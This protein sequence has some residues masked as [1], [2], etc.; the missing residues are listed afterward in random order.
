MTDPAAPDAVDPAF[1]PLPLVRTAMILAAIGLLIVVVSLAT[2]IA[3][4]RTEGRLSQDL[5]SVFWYFDVGR[6]HNVAT[7]YGAGL[8]LIVAAVA[9]GIA[10][11]RPRRRP[12]WWFVA[13]V[14][15]VAS[16]DEHLQLRERLDG[17]A[18]ALT[19]LLPF[20]LWFTWVLVG[21]PIAV[22]VGAIL[23]RTVLALPRPSRWGI[24]VA[25]ALF[26]L[27]SVGVET[28]NGRTLAD[29]DGVVTNAYLY[30]T[31]VEELLEMAAVGLALASLLALVQHSRAAGLVRLDPRIDA[32]PPVHP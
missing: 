12:S 3:H 5:H 9:A 10:L 31:M 17:P 4:Q 1:R 6:E 32:P 26:V 14:A 11:M 20:D 21:L 18:R 8:W 2:L 19:G 28:L 7:W 27:G 30:G 25:G 22:V 24:L 16:A 13:A 29:A 23:L 15:T